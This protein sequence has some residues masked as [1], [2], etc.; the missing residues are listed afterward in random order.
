MITDFTEE[1]LQ[2]A[3]LREFQDRVKM[4]LDEEINAA[5]PQKWQGKVIVTCKSGERY[6]QFVEYL[7]GDPQ[8]P[9]TRYV[10]LNVPMR[11]DNYSQ[12]DRMVP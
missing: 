11:P 2:D 12:A 1:A 10:Q 7:K 9:L 5:F 3:S 4:E 6:E 8:S